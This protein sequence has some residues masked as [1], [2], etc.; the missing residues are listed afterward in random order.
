MAM[1]EVLLPVLALAVG[2]VLGAIFFGGLWWTVRQGVLSPQPVVW[3]LGSLL[4]RM[5][6]TLVGFYLVSGGQ[7]QRL[8]LCLAGFILARFGVNWLTRSP[9]EL[10]SRSAREPGYA[11]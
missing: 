2:I 5:S 3:F 11:P 7:W 1:N 4:L 6:L 8:L 9:G 10:R